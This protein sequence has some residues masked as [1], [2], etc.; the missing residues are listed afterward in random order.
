MTV[1]VTIVDYGVGNLFSVRKG[2]EYCGSEPIMATTAE[3]ILSADRLLLPGVGAFGDSM[4]GMHRT[5]LVEPVLEFARSGR[6]LLGICLGMQMLLSESEEFG[7]HDGLGL[8]PGKVVAIPQTGANGK[9]H[10]I[11]HVGWNAITPGE[12]AGSWEGTLLKG[13][14]DG[15]A[16]YFVHSFQA[17]TDDPQHQLATCDYNGRTVTGVV[18]KDNVVGCQFHPEKSAEAGLAVIRNFLSM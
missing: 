1:T 11:P 14:H 2:L 5:A 6:P 16:F 7:R 18:R 8:V 10:R 3:E 17:V 15:T 12:A 13:I 9:A 4:A